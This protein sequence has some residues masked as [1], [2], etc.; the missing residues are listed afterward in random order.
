MKH[1]DF[2]EALTFDDVLISPGY[3]CVL[4][5]ETVIET[6]LTKN[7]KLKIPFLSAAMDTVT[8]SEMALSMAREGGCGIIHKNLTPENQAL[9]VKKVKRSESSIISNPVVISPG[10]Q[11]RVAVGLMGE[12]SI[13]GLPVVDS[14]SR[15]IG[16]VTARDVRFE[17][18][19][20]VYIRDVM[21]SD[22]I[23]APL[24]INTT[25]ALDIMHRHRIEKLILLNTDGT[26]GGLLTLKDILSCE[27]FSHSAK[28]SMGR[29]IVGAAVGAGEKDKIRVRLLAQEQVDVICV[30]TAHGHTKSVG[31]MVKWIKANYPEIDIIAGNIA[32]A[33]GA[34]FL[35][36][37]GADAVKVGI[38]PGSI[39][40][41][42]IV[43]GIGVPQLTAIM[44]V[45]EETSKFNI[46]L[47]ADGGIKFSGDIVKALA[48]GADT[49]MMGSLLAGTDETPG[50]I[51]LYQGRSYK[52]YRGMGSL[53]AMKQ[54]SADRYFQS[55]T[56]P[57][58]LVPEGIEGRVPSKGPVHA[59]LAQLAGG[60]RS[61]MGYTGS[62]NLAELKENVRFLRISSSGLRESHVHDVIITKEAPNYK[63][64]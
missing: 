62:S 24:D 60:L 22:L 59:T 13:S 9:L 20:S 50:E 5:S 28:D 51:I 15:P 34:A 38:G 3:S 8:E 18:N 46:P 44:D 17:K 12:N 41:T 61:G 7:I 49:V 23:T 55:E 30:D 64:Q 52:Q 57:G 31:D 16:I 56:N 4:P 26:L 29:L 21:T 2:I 10:D 63:I 53:G 33:Q 35:I 19:L 40:T 48:A 45:Y 36:E 39:C 25:D 42:R 43:S 54:G 37:A 1:I 14:N 27:K 11:L 58:K 32:T 47:I 6:N